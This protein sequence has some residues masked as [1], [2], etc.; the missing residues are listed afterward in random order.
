M[1]RVL[2]GG[3]DFTTEGTEGGVR[4]GVDLVTSRE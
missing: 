2:A 1:V 3:E 4:E